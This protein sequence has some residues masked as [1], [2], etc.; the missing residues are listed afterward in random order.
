[1]SMRLEKNGRYES[2]TIVSLEEKTDRNICP[3][4]D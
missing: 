4:Q 1:M 3:L 2:L